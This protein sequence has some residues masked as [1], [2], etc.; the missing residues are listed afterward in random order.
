[1][2]ILAINAARGVSMSEKTRW[3]IM[4]T[5]YIARLFATGLTALPDAEIA[6]VGSRTQETAD[7]FGDQFHIPRRHASYEALAQ[8]PNVDVIYISTPHN[9]HCENTL[10]CLDAGKPVLCEKPLAI[11]MSE[12]QRMVK[13]ARE[14]K[15][16][17]ME[18]MW[19][20]YLPT[21]VRTRELIAAGT[22]GGVRMVTADFGFRTA[23]NPQ[24]RL[25]NPQNGGGALLDVGVYPISLAHML[26]GTPSRIMSMAQLGETGVDEQSAYTLS[27]PHGELALLFS[28]IRTQTA[29]EARIAGTEGLIRLPDWWHGRRLTLTLNGKPE[30]VMELPFEGNGY[31]YEAAEVAACLRAGKLES[32]IMTLDDS[33]AII[34]TLDTMRGQWGLNYPM[35]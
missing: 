26:L 14:T 22:I 7:R 8:D 23:V 27:Y 15:L 6:A 34:Q 20:R 16:F 18:A 21:L 35:E 31:N 33:L 24:G 25:F 2:H 29:H 4:G 13:R 3:G 19:T 30:E 10:M 5:G 9:L 32:E 11:N 12:V 1:M 17:L 28:A